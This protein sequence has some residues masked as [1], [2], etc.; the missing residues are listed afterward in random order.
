MRSSNHLMCIA[1]CIAV[2]AIVGQLPARADSAQLDWQYRCL[3]DPNAVCYDATPS[4]LDPPVAGTTAGSHAA[5]SAPAPTGVRPVVPEGKPTAGAATGGLAAP[6]V[7]AP[8]PLRAIAARLQ[9]RQPTPADLTALQ[10]QAAGG[11]ARALELLAWAE[12]VGAGV[13]RDPVQA[14]FLYGIAAAAGAPTGRRDQAA[15]YEKDLT[16]EE[17]QEILLIENGNLARHNE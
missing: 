3:K 10:A 14:Y 11:N 4:G 7:Q 6:A 8:D 5:P 13:S 16:A 2:L 1:A 15:I 17:R 12:L 9:A